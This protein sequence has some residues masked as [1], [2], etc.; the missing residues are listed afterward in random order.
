MTYRETIIFEASYH[1]HIKIL[2]FLRCPKCSP[3]SSLY[4]SNHGDEKVDEVLFG[5]LTCQTCNAE[6]KIQNGIPR[7]VELKEDYCK[8]FGF[9]W[10]KW[11]KI[12]ID[13]LSGH[14]ISSDR[15]FRDS[16][17]KPESL[18]G[19]LILDAGCGAGRFAD[20]VAAHGATVVAVDLSDAVEACQKTTSIHGGR[21][22]CLQASLTNLPIRLGIF[23]A[24]YCMGVIQHTPDPESVIR[25]LPKYLKPGGKLAYNFYEEGIWRRLQIFKYLLRLV[26]PYLSVQV[27]MNISKTLVRYLFPVTRFL[28]RLPKFRIL[29]HFIPIAAVHDRQLSESAQF[30]W[31]LLDTFDWYGARY[32]KCQNHNTVARQLRE[33]GMLE[34]DSCPG[35]ARAQKSKI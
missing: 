14:T 13:R 29:N 27:T 28:A 12:Q 30:I 22:H 16:T 17:W 20:I 8:N 7:F 5:T 31:T 18:K 6:F 21:A 26:T 2:N 1:V 19:K 25:T 32:E 23:D 35:L 10:K 34:I 15:F 3:D 4:I 33:E 24:I 9:Q 11:R